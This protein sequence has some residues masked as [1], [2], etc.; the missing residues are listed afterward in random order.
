LTKPERQVLSLVRPADIDPA[1]GL[2]LAALHDTRRRLHEQL[3]GLADEF[4]DAIPS[5]GSSTI[6]SLLYHI[7]AIEADWL[8]DDIKCLEEAHWPDAV[9]D[10][11]PV[12]VR[13]DGTTL[14][15]YTGETLGQHVDRLEKVRM[16]LVD[17]VSLMTPDDLHV[18]N[19]R[20]AY[21]VSPAWALHHLMQHEAEHRAQIGRA[22]ELLGIGQKW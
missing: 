22:R 14:S 7:A 9:K 19:E 4:I 3:E 6:G 8:Y 12:Q 5:D 18:L 15:R 20:S 1:V 21:D 10:L 2:W 13:E 11:F 17:T 16:M